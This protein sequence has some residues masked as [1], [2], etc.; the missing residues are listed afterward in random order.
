[1]MT[2]SWTLTRSL[3]EFLDAAGAF[4][5][6]E[7]V[8]NTVPLTICETLRRLGPAAVGDSPDA[9]AASLTRQLAASGME[10]AGA[11]LAAADEAAF[12]AAWRQT[13]GGRAVAR[14]RSRLFRLGSLLPP[15]PL[16]AGAA[17]FATCYD[18]ELLA[19]WHAA[20]HDEIGE[21]AA[22]NPARTVENRLSHRGLMLWESGGRPVAMASITTEVAGAVRVNAV[23]TPPEHR[24]RG[25]GGAVTAAVSQSALDRGAGA[26][27]LFTDLANPTSNALYPRLGYR[28]VADRVL[29][30]L[31]SG[32]GP[33]DATSPHDVTSQHG[34]SS[35]RS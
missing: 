10:L 27:V 20:F 19:S 13:T 26:V 31:G 23:Y 2:M 24:G 5:R 12:A 14:H 32:P 8:H 28:P 6:A 33:H 17:R 18:A 7:P 16:P 35:Y 30:A 4:L 1:M 11:N 29:L 3:D 15:D 25:Y 22:G 9:S 34:G 21:A